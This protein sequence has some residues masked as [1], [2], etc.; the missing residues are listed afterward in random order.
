MEEY[1]ARRGTSEDAYLPLLLGGRLGL[2]ECDVVQSGF[3]GGRILIL[4]YCI[5]RK[6][7]CLS[8][9]CMETRYVYL[10]AMNMKTY[11][12]HLVPVCDCSLSRLAA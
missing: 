11:M 7:I 1:R 9:R 2:D 3:Q 5:T 10:K 8:H 6:R 12:I 4:S